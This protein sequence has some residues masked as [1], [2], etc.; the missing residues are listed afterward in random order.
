MKDKEIGKI[1]E[2][3]YQKM[4]SHWSRHRSPYNQNGFALKHEQELYDAVCKF[5]SEEKT[6][7]IQ[8]K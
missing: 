2:D 1:V 6:W 5:K 7:L 3:L 4:L 8:Q